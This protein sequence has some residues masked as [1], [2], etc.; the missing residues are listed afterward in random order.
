MPSNQ[1]NRRFRTALLGFAA[2]GLIAILPTSASGAVLR[3]ECEDFVDYGSGAGASPTGGSGGANRVYTDTSTGLDGQK[4]SGTVTTNYSVWSQEGGTEYLEYVLVVPEGGYYEFTIRGACPVAT[5]T[6]RLWD[7]T[8]GVIVDEPLDTSASGGWVGANMAQYVGPNLLPLSP[9]QIR[10]RMYIT[11]TG[12]N[13]DW[14]ELRRI[15]DNTA[16]G[17]V[18]GTVKDESGNP[19]PWA[20][21]STYVFES[22]LA[23]HR[24][25]TDAQ[26]RY[27]LLAP[28]GSEVLISAIAPGY[29]TPS[30]TAVNVSDTQ[31]ATANFVLSLDGKYEAEFWSDAF[32]A[33]VSAP[34]DHGVAVGDNVMN[35]SNGQYVGTFNT[36]NG[37][38]EWV[39]YK[40]TAPTAGLYTLMLNYATTGSGTWLVNVAETGAH[41]TQTLGSTGGWDYYTDQAFDL[42]VALKQGVNTLRFTTEGA[43]AINFDY[44]T[45]TNTGQVPGT[46]HGTVMN[47]S[48]SPKTP[49]SGATIT[50]KDAADMTVAVTTT[51][52]SGLYS[53][54]I[55]AGF[56]TLIPEKTGFE[57]TPK[58]A[59]VTEGG[60]TQ[61]DFDMTQGRIRG[62]VRNQLGEPIAET[63]VIAYADATG[64]LFDPNNPAYN[65]YK[66]NQTTTDA[67][68]YY[69][70]AVRPGSAVVVAGA[71]MSVHAEKTV[72]ANPSA[73]V[74]L[75]VLKLSGGNVVDL[76]WNHDWFSD[77]PTGGLPNGRH[78]VDGIFSLPGASSA[79]TPV[80]ACGPTTVTLSDVPFKIGDVT[81]TAR[82]VL[83]MDAPNNLIPVPPGSYNAAVVL[84]TSSN[85]NWPSDRAD[86][87]SNGTP[88]P[89]GGALIN[90]TDSTSDVVLFALPNWGYNQG[91]YGKAWRENAW[92]VIQWAYRWVDGSSGPEY[93]KFNGV[94]VVLPCNPAKTVQSLTLIPDP[95][96][97]TTG[98]NPFVFA[99]TMAKA[100]VIQPSAAR[101]LR[102]AAGL[103]PA[104][105]AEVA[106]LDWELNGKVDI[107]DAVAMAKQGR[108]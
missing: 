104:N 76:A 24:A 50:V 107:A 16:F 18:T 98:T 101:A 33:P 10:L 25:S 63:R 1:I 45:L 2:L 52:A 40:V 49:I 44:F 75:T 13:N 6:L 59:N 108:L 56:Y 83:S 64:M 78:D 7:I 81:G 11:G 96:L 87:Y 14:F 95:S 36:W 68:G 102:I 5:S 67:N 92:E 19:L 93:I 85:G 77:P 42:P 72:T 20:Q 82:N 65:G 100:A 27:S 22:P 91:A 84:G 71:P 69:E 26:G 51:N 37:V 99:V 48:V 30:S 41:F 17:I 35:A 23:S 74:D 15:S 106:A 21:V 79:W 66:L 46:V 57:S 9:G 34:V 39:E 29:G 86:Q 58:P 38:P 31:S 70:M 62:Y 53:V 43:G 32:R 103:A 4:I 61:V 55:S 47:A 90:Y 12:M 88:V 73:N 60:S 80:E 3:I 89:N 54:I 105:A 94:A 28:V 8:N 97:A